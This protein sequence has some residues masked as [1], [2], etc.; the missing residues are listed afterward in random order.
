M[1]ALPN[2]LPARPDIIQFP[3]PELRL[4][5]RV[6]AE[7]NAA[8][9]STPDVL[10]CADLFNRFM[11][12]DTEANR[13]MIALG[14]GTL[15]RVYWTAHELNRRGDGSGR[16]D[17]QQLVDVL[18]RVGV[19]ATV[20]TIR[21]NWIKDGDGL[22]WDRDGKGGLYLVSYKND[23]KDG[24][25][26]AQLLTRLALEAGKP[27][28]IAT[29]Y[30]G[31]KFIETPIN[32]T[33]KQW[34]GNSLAAWHNSRADHTRRIS[35]QTLEMLWGHTRKTLTGWER[36]AGITVVKCYANF[37]DDDAI[38]EHA[39]PTLTIVTAADGTKAPRER[40]RARI[41]N[42]YNAPS[43]TERQHQ[44]TPRKAYRRTAA[45][46][47]RANVS[48]DTPDSDHGAASSNAGVGFRTGRRSFYADDGATRDAFG[49]LHS[50]LDRHYTDKAPHYVALGWDDRAKCWLYEQSSTGFQQTAIRER[51]S[52][53]AEHYYFD[54]TGGRCKRLATWKVQ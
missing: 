14:L 47:E 3:Y 32:G 20:S 8:D 29:N 39:Y 19:D 33:T 41:S 44:A 38:P 7:Q 36:E 42:I 1:S 35:R 31:S 18:V 2:I 15:A 27:G 24:R 49:K 37:T 13:I 9:V 51:V 52:I 30:V 48:V 6:S 46:L 54:T 45:A 53:Q 12:V 25:G 40:A 50:H 16:V 21:H 28:L 17:E 23:R 11:A 4:V 22:L 26:L 5:K 10:P 43:M 34:Y